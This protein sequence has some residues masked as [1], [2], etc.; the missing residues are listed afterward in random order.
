MKKYFFSIYR[1]YGCISRQFQLIKKQK[2]HLKLMC[3][4][5]D[6]RYSVNTHKKLIVCISTSWQCKWKPNF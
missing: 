6:Y 1:Y 2:T 3:V 4:K 5:E